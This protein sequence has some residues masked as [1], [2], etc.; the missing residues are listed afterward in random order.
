VGA[1]VKDVAGGILAHRSQDYDPEK[2]RDALLGLELRNKER[3]RSPLR[4]LYFGPDTLEAIA[5]AFQ[6][7]GAPVQFFWPPTSQHAGGWADSCPP[8]QLAAGLLAYRT[9]DK[10]VLWLRDTLGSLD[11]SALD[12]ILKAWGIDPDVLVCAELDRNA[13]RKVAAQWDASVE[14]TQ[15][16]AG[17]K[18]PKRVEW[19][20]LSYGRL[21]RFDDLWPPDA[22]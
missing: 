13:Y 15:H 12:D 1:K 17:G 5:D 3:G 10:V 2:T 8:D 20:N 11:V 9:P 21:A 22:A 14:H 18:V 19:R 6:R 16:R 7:E 4:V